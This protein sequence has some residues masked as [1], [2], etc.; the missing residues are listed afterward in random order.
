MVHIE[1][2]KKSLC[3]FRKIPRQVILVVRPIAPIHITIKSTLNAAP[4]KISHRYHQL[5]NFTGPLLLHLTRSSKQIK[6]C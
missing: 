5:H 6:L 3:K 4:C 1:L 2:L